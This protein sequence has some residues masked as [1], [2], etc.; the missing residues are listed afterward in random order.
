VRPLPGVA[1]SGTASRSRQGVHGV[2]LKADQEN[3]QRQPGRANLCSGVV[4]GK[5]SCVQKSGLGAALTVGAALAHEARYYFGRLKDRDYVPV[6]AVAKRKT[7]LGPAME[8]EALPHIFWESHL[9][10]VL[11]AASHSRDQVVNE[12]LPRRRFV[13]RESALYEVAE[14]IIVSGVLYCKRTRAD[15]RSKYAPA[16]RLALPRSPVYESRNM[17]FVSMQCATTWFGHWLEDE[18]PSLVLASG[19]APTIAIRR[20]VYD[21]EPSYLAAFGVAEPVRAG[22]AICRDLLYL[23]EPALQ[24]PIKAKRCHY[25]RG[26]LKRHSGTAKRVF[27]LRG[28]TGAPRHLVNEMEIA[29][30]LEDEGFVAIE[31]GSCTLDEL[32]NIACGADLFVSVEGSHLAHILYMG[33]DFG[34]FV[35][36]NPPYQVHTTVAGCGQFFGLRG[37]MFIGTPVGD[38]RTD[39]HVDPDELLRFIEYTE[40]VHKKERHHLA[41]FVRRLFDLAKG[42]PADLW[43]VDCPTV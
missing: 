34:C 40:S 21:Q 14:A 7:V 39:F 36:M 31:P 38:S 23:D 43:D 24:S 32:L 11:G 2:P 26:R 35:I 30:R 1:A 13:V 28:S 19:F 18:A 33:A 20:P 27:L 16:P 22:T 10:R 5:A 25:L 3:G 12:D 15:C 8:L 9:D 41:A 37:S 17:S 6:E 4:G 42:S 29:A